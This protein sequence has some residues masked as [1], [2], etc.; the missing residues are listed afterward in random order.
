MPEQQTLVQ[1]IAAKVRAL[2]PEDWFGNA[3]RR[4][5]HTATMISDFAVEHELLD[6]AK[7]LSFKALKGKAE[8]EYSNALKNYSEEER[9]KVDTELKRRTMDAAARQAEATA[10]KAEAEVRLAHLKEVEARLALFDNLKARN[11]IPIWDEDGTMRVIRVSQGFAW[12]RLQDRLLTTGEFPKL[13]EEREEPLLT[14]VTVQELLTTAQELHDS[15][16]LNPANINRILGKSIVP[17]TEKPKKK[18]K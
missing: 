14:D 15:D 17:K 11:A 16:E 9:N 6:T 7:D 2:L 3:G 18:K 5:K 13:V 10:N 4:W 8:A 1:R 12:D